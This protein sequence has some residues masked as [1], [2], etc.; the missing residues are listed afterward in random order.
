M[1]EQ[2]A[3]EAADALNALRN[4]QASEAP[5]KQASEAPKVVSE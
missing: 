5:K 1:Q 2:N 4:K 3:K